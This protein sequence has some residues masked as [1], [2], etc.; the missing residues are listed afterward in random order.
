MDVNAVASVPAVREAISIIA[1]IDPETLRE[2]VE[3]ASQ[4]APTGDEARRAAY[5]RRRFE[6]LGLTAVTTDEAGNVLAALT[7]P[8]SNGSVYPA[9]VVIAA[10]L[11]TVFPDATQLSPRFESGVIHLPGISDNARGLAALLAFARAVRQSGL[12]TRRAIVLAATVGEEG[13]G[14][15]RGVKHL[16]REG[17][18]M[19]GAFAFVAIDGAGDARI[20]VEAVGATRMRV[21]LRGPGGHSWGDRGRANPAHLMARAIAAVDRLVPPGDQPYSVSVGRLGGGTSINSIPSETWFELDLRAIDREVLS[22][23][24]TESVQLIHEAAGREGE[25]VAR[26][27]AVVVEVSHIGARPCGRVPTESPIVQAAIDATRLVGAI[28]EL[29]AS[30]TDANVPISLDIPAIAIGAGGRAGGVH[31][32]EEWYENHNGVRGIERILLTVLALAEPHLGSM[33]G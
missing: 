26:S 14:D 5:V 24:E 9:P 4:P 20:V 3:I 12:R 19:R 21:T 6:E 22:W 15:L 23:L 27:G 8:A 1:R 25:N 29:V 28:P 31:T 30:S 13:L 33:E 16:F 7:T 17:S 32:I 11:D 18:P 2:Q 10:H